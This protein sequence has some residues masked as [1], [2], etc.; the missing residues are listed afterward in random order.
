MNIVIVGGGPAGLMAAIAAASQGIKVTVC[1]QLAH[2]GKKLLA[3]GGG[4]CNLSNLST[5]E[6]F[7]DSFGRQGRFILPALKSLSP[8]DL[9]NFFTQRGLPLETVDGFHLFPKSQRAGDVCQLLI[10][11]CHQLGVK[12]LTSTRVTALQITDNHIS[13][14]KTAASSIPARAVIIAAGGM[15]YPKLGGGD[16]G[17]RLAAQAGHKIIP[18]LPGMTGLKTVEDWPRQH[19]G[20][21]FSNVEVVINL[22]KLRRRVSRGELLFTHNGISGPAVID[23][24]GTI[25][26]RLA[27][28]TTPIPLQIR[29][30]SKLTSDDW[31]RRFVAWRNSRKSLKNLLAA[32]MPSAMAE[33][34]CQLAGG[35]A[36]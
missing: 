27:Q 18:P 24:A 6:Q 7:V 35:I 8:N 14:V 29:F 19:S 2:P 1:E 13:G 12:F 32:D 3:S 16:S 23:L 21:S 5:L 20:I 30:F 22:P 36:K 25:A 9:I 15:G 4:K 28:Q 11:E 33:V 34:I 26:R 10:E 31:Q 17:Y